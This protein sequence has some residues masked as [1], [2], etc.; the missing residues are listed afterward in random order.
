MFDKSMYCSPHSL[1]ENKCEQQTLTEKDMWE[2]HEYSLWKDVLPPDLNLIQEIKRIG[3]PPSFSFK[4]K[5]LPELINMIGTALQNDITKVEEQNPNKTNYI[6]C[7]GTYAIEDVRKSLWNRAAVLQGD[8]QGFLRSISRG[9][10]VWKTL[11]C[12][13]HGAER[14]GWSIREKRCKTA[15]P[16]LPLTSASAKTSPLLRLVQL[17]GGDDNTCKEYFFKITR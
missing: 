17:S 12:S 11:P 1:I 4:I 16:R 8:H 10:T 14:S 15:E 13:I 7:G 9:K 6:L 5:K 3:G 2:K